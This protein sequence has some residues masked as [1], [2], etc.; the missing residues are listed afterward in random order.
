MLQLRRAISSGQGVV[1]VIRGIKSLMIW[2]ISRQ[3]SGLRISA[4]F[5]LK[6]EEQM[7]GIT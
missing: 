3:Q 6:T 5:R 7:E 4:L 1:G 2:V